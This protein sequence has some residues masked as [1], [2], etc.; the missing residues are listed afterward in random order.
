MLVIFVIMLRMAD[1]RRVKR[2]PRQC[3]KSS[4]CPGK[5][6]YCDPETLYCRRCRRTCDI[7]ELPR[8]CENYCATLSDGNRPKTRQSND[9]SR[10]CKES[11]ECP[12]TR[13]YCDPETLYC[14]QCK[15][16]CKTDVVPTECENYCATL[17]DGD[18]PKTTKYIWLF[19]FVLSIVIIRS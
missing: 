15:R 4:D 7:D 18:K 8:E 1:P 13:Q 9:D 5:R 12:D 11:A 2:D 14:T 3:K 6:Q 19:C 10:R 16:T 17:S